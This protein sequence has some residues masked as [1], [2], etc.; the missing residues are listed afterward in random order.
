MRLDSAWV[1]L[2]L[3]FGSGRDL[4]DYFLIRIRL[5]LVVNPTNP[6]KLQ[7]ELGSL[8]PPTQLGCRISQKPT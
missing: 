1:D 3:E 6:P 7:P 8:K 2:K 5:R 4:V